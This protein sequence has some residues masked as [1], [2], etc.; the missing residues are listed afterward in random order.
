MAIENTKRNNACHPYQPA[1][2]NLEAKIQTIVEQLL[3]KYTQSLSNMPKEE[4]V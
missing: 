2:V 3:T 1:E 4:N